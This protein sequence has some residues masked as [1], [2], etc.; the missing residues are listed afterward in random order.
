MNGIDGLRLIKGN[1]IAMVSLDLEGKTFGNLTAFQKTNERASNGS[2][3][4]LCVCDCGTYTK[5]RSGELVSGNIKSCGYAVCRLYAKGYIGSRFGRLLVLSVLYNP[6]N[7]IKWKCLCTCGNTV[8]VTT[9]RLKSGKTKSCGCLSIEMTRER[10]KKDITGKRHG[11][12]T[13][14]EPTKNHKGRELRWLCKCDCG[15]ITYVQS[16]NLRNGHTRSCGCLKGGSAFYL[17]A[18]QSE[19]L[20]KLGISVNPYRRK[21]SLYSDT[22]SVINLIAYTKSNYNEE[23]KIHKL[24]A[25]YRAIHPNQPTG[26]EWYFPSEKVI[27]VVKSMEY[28]LQEIDYG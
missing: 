14:I 10:N 13:V 17:Y 24:L 11:M 25:E 19:G 27:N 23:R 3:L 22:K 1:W 7:L 9:P 5:V 4:W 26:K 16:S 8:F 21:N 20:I 12:L 6:P 18:M 2:A 15:N 28:Q